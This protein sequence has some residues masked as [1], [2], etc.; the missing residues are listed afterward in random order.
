MHERQ[1]TDGEDERQHAIEDIN[2]DKH[3]HFVDIHQLSRLTFV[4]LF[5]FFS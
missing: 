1:R 4:F 3:L 5:Y 2:D